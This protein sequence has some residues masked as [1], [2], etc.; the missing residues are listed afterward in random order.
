MKKTHKIFDIPLYHTNMVVVIGTQK[1]IT[2]IMSNYTS[3]EEKSKVGRACVTSI[4]EYPGW[5]FVLFNKDGDI[6]DGVIVHE[7]LHVL[8]HLYCRLQESMD[9]MEKDAFLLQWVFETIKK[10]F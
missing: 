8:Y 9:G 10:L 1:H 2:Q 5:I 4:N 3:D 7:S 6:N